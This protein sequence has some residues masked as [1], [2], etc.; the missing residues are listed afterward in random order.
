MIISVRR[1]LAGFCCLVCFGVV[2][3]AQQQH[4]G[5]G[6]GGASI[7]WVDG[8]DGTA[9]SLPCLR[10]FQRIRMTATFV[11]YQVDVRGTRIGTV[12]QKAHLGLRTPPASQWPGERVDLRLAQRAIFFCCWRFL[13]RFLTTGL[14]IV[15]VT[16]YPLVS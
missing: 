6:R 12:A 8:V 2:R 16:D 15:V 13:A 9:G 11:L 7:L 14:L 1:S 5:G 4:L 3:R 10:H